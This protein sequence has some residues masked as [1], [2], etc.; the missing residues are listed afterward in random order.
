MDNSVTSNLVISLEGELSSTFHVHLALAI[1]DRDL[2]NDPGMCGYGAHEES[3]DNLQ[4][5]ILA[6][7]KLEGIFTYDQII[8]KFWDINLEITEGEREVDWY[9]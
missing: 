2:R 5:E 6:I 1:L 3:E 7:S 4:K 8:E 9:L